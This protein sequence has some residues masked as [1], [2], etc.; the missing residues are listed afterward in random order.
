M[1]GS[2]T[3]RGLA[4]ATVVLALTGAWPAAAVLAPSAAMSADGPV[5][6]R[7][8][9][10]TLSP[11]ADGGRVAF[12]DLAGSDGDEPLTSVSVRMLGVSLATWTSMAEEPS[13]AGTYRLLLPDAHPGPVHVGLEV[14]ERPQGPEVIDLSWTFNGSLVA[15]EPLT[16]IPAGLPGAPPV[17]F[18]ALGFG[19]VVAWSLT[20]ARQFAARSGE[21]P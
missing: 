14:R 13:A 10:L 17:G 21:R 11:A 7:L 12:V 9:Y 5:V 1:I 4:A 18:L 3:R 15:G 16:F 8:R 20:A 19:A 2:R 6:P